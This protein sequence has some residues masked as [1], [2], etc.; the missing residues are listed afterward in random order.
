MFRSFLILWLLICLAAISYIDFRRQVI[1][2]ICLF[3]MLPAAFFQTTLLP[4]RSHFLAAGVPIALFFLMAL[5]A[6]GLHSD[7]PVGM[8]DAKLLAVIGLISGPQALLFTAAAGS[9]FCGSTAAI[10]I[11]MKKVT[12]KSRIAFGPFLAMAYAILFFV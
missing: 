6:A 3:L 4:P 11:L 1:P 12:K 7:V 8:G 2:D 5:I 10:L 9:L